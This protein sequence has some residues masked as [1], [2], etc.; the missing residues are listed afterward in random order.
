MFPGTAMAPPMTMTSLARRKAVGERA[1]TWAKVV[2][3][4]RA[5]R[6]IVLG[7]LVFRRWRISC[8]E[9]LF[10]GVKRVVWVARSV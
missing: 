5:M 10:E 7:G 1:A 2:R 4:P 3:G 8:G 9:G 6:V